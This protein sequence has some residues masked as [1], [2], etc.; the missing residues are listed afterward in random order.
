MKCIRTAAMVFCFML[1][2]QSCVFAMAAEE[3]KLL[4]VRQQNQENS[5]KTADCH[6][7]VLPEQGMVSFHFIQFSDVNLQAA[8][9]VLVYN[10]KGQKIAVF[11][12]QKEKQEYLTIRLLPGE[13]YIE[14][15]SGGNPY[16]ITV[17]L[18]S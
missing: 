15:V 13:Y 8:W 18:D 4:V 10:A 6:K 1:L 2:I 17:K 12:A 14:I 5:K 16:H 7:I 3:E 9:Q 11:L